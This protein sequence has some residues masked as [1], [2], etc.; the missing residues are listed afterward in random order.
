M[1]QRE[2]IHLFFLRFVV[3]KLLTLTVRYDGMYLRVSTCRSLQ[4][5]YYRAAYVMHGRRDWRCRAGDASDVHV[6]VGVAF[7]LAI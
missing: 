3:P 5:A 7:R 6:R 1:K 4:G 2:Y